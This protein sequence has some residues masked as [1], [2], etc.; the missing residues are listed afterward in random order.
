[1]LTVSIKEV[2]HAPDGQLSFRKR[3]QLLLGLGPVGDRG[4]VTV[5]QIRRSKLAILCVRKVL[6]VWECTNDARHPQDLVE[7]TERLV[8]GYEAR[9]ASADDARMLN[10]DAYQYG[11]ALLDGAPVEERPALYVAHAA[12]CAALVATDDEIL[13]PDEG[14]TEAELNDPQDPDLWDC[15]AWAAAAYAGEFPWT[16]HKE[17]FDVSRNREF[18]LWYLHDALA[19]ARQPLG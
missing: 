3:R 16:N 13:V 17:L 10:E 18:W 9:G 12:V 8:L 6:S 11:G 5:G 14:V 2:L 4:V 1:M 19:V 15:A 7:R